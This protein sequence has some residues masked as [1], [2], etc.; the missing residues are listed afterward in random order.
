MLSPDRRRG[1]G[2][3]SHT[4]AGSETIRRCSATLRS[5]SPRQTATEVPFLASL[6]RSLYFLDHLTS[7]QLDSGS[8]F[9]YVHMY[10]MCVDVLH[11]SLMGWLECVS[12]LLSLSLLTVCCVH[13]QAGCSMGSV[14]K[15]ADMLS[16]HMYLLHLINPEVHTYTHTSTCTIILISVYAL[17]RLQFEL[18]LSVR[19]SSQILVSSQFTREPGWSP[20]SSSPY[21]LITSIH[22]YTYVHVRVCVSI[23]INIVL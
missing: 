9:R 12:L 19:T 16:T 11:C 7:P 23:I 17:C 8:V 3:S 4:V 10:V 5:F 13:F 14:G 20:T 21:R 6:W 22:H 18:G 2:R 1:G 15:E